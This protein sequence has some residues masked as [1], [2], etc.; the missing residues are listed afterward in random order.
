MSSEAKLHA[1][2]AEQSS[3]EQLLPHAAGAGA[4]YEDKAGGWML[5]GQRTWFLDVLVDCPVPC[6]FMASDYQT[7]REESEKATQLVKRG[8]K[9]LREHACIGELGPFRDLSTTITGL[10]SMYSNRLGAPPPQKPSTLHSDP[11]YTLLAAGAQ[12]FYLHTDCTHGKR[13]PPSIP[14]GLTVHPNPLP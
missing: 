2:A 5:M 3:L 10:I 9:N 12:V 4:R 11:F 1:Y 14:V 7:R 8:S 13:S 6:P